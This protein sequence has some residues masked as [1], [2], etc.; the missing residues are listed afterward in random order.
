MVK[1]EVAVQ[2]TGERPG[3][4]S[5]GA[6]ESKSAGCNGRKCLIVHSRDID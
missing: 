6:P 1:G 3:S 5:E 4:E 2:E